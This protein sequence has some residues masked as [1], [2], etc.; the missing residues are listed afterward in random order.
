MLFAIRIKVSLSFLIT[1]H[2]QVTRCPHV[3]IVRVTCTKSYWIACTWIDHVGAKRRA[4][5]YHVS[6]IRCTHWTISLKVTNERAAD[7]Y[8]YCCERERESRPQCRCVSV[9]LW[10]AVWRNIN[11]GWCQIFSFLLGPSYRQ[12]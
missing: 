8:N 1:D 10:A 7:G 5:A 9:S 4:R 12:L 3:L 11:R 2:G 6:M